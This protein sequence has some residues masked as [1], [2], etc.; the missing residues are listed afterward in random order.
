[1]QKCKNLRAKRA[2]VGAWAWRVSGAALA[3]L[4][5]VR[6]DLVGLCGALV[7]VESCARF[8]AFAWILA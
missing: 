4:C 3:W 5:R 1:M 7:R 2:L 8:L 6:G